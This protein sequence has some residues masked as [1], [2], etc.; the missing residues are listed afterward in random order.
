M[1]QQIR[2]D[3]E[4]G[5]AKPEKAPEIQEEGGGA[6]RSNQH[7]HEVNNYGRHHVGCGYIG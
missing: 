2:I 6:W 3:P 1:R 7:Q 5:V 4:S